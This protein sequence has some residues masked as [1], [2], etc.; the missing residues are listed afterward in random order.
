MK[1]VVLIILAIL[2][3]PPLVM[4]LLWLLSPAN[5]LDIYIFDKT[6]LDKNVQEHL[7]LNW[8]L[9]HNKFTKSNNT[10][11]SSSADYYGFFPLDSGKFFIREVDTSQSS[12]D[13][14]SKNR[15][16]IYYTDTYGVYSNEW[17]SGTIDN[18]RSKLIYGGLSKTDLRLIDNSVK[19]GNLLIMEF[20]TFA[21]PT[22]RYI[23]DSVER[24]TGIKWSGWSGRFY[25]SLDT[26]KNK[27]IPLWM[28][29][30]YTSQHGGR[31]P[32]KNGGIVFVHENNRIEI[33][34]EDLL[35]PGKLPTIIASDFLRDRFG[36]K[37]LTE[38]PF[39]FDIVEADE[40]YQISASHSMEVN[41]KGR[42][43][44]CKYGIPVSFPAVLFSKDS[45]I[46]YFAGDF[47]DNKVNLSLSRFKY[48]EQFRALLTSSSREERN[49][50]FWYFY[51]PLVS[52]ILRD[53][54][55]TGNYR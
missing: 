45:R 23:R 34:G 26:A 37:H 8:I 49:T 48:I 30:G 42:D 55:K 15:S 31:W 16:V 43:S 17:N 7:S 36:V 25:N 51:Y 35:L 32:Y 5:P 33:I 39:W 24:L 47:S 13:I 46:I 18:E 12:L 53:E 38:Y 2:L 4:Y 28:K 21:S 19:K 44:L 9:T 41:Q 6:V 1:R 29:R 50:F 20:N 52:N 54:Y 22:P 27:D 3:V 10:L 14:I 11:Y 40:S